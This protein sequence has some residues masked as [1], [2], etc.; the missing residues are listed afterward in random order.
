LRSNLKVPCTKENFVVGRNIAIM[1]AKIHVENLQQ[2]YSSIACD[3]C[4]LG[5][6]YV[7]AVERNFCLGCVTSGSVT[8]TQLLCHFREC[9]C[10]TIVVSLQGVLL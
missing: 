1:H 3:L 6:V 2:K 10:N 4:L 7:R 9:Y 5:S 8:V